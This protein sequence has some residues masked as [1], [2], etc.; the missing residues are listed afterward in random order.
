MNTIATI[1]SFL[2]PSSVIKGVGQIYSRTGST[3]VPFNITLVKLD[4]LEKSLQDEH[5]FEYL[6]SLL[7]SG[8]NELFS[9]FTYP[10]R[11]REWLGGR[12]AAKVAVLTLLQIK[13]TSEMLT[14]LT[15]LPTENGSPRLSSSLHAPDQLPVLSISHSDRFAV[16]MAVKAESC[17]IDIQK[18]SEKTVRVV[19]R[20]CEPGELQLLQDRA[21]KL[22][23][24]ERLTLLWSAKEALKK[25]L[26]H[27]QPII[28]QG[29]ALQSLAAN[30]YF[31]LHLQF[32]GDR[33]HP[34]EVTAVM[35]E[36]C[37]LAY[38]IVTSRHA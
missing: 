23:E 17:G 37:M 14:T 9:T 33:D 12:L 7:S 21:P 26:L 2:P 30:Q 16:A 13:S 38:T 29:V 18:I 8:E 31:T 36:D 15:I 19:D 5:S 6:L 3:P 35:L 22:N 32:P 20:F 28:F 4:D 1:E 27:D 34:A 24:K 25:A 10:K 11:K